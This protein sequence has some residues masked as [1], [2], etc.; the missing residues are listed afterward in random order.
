[1]NVEEILGGSVGVGGDG[2]GNRQS[3]CPNVSPESFVTIDGF[4]TLEGIAQR[5]AD[6]RFLY[7]RS[8][9]EGEGVVRIPPV[10]EM[11]LQ[12]A[13]TEEGTKYYPSQSA[14]SLL[15]G[16]FEMKPS[17]HL[18]PS[19]PTTSFSADQMIQFARAVG[20]ASYSMLEDLLLKARGGSGAHPMTSR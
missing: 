6:R 9:G 10:E 14:K 8:D 5:Q 1:M 20:L 16:Y 17:I 18:H 3:V 7:A 2:G 11:F 4:S 19:H 13:T 15:K 12:G